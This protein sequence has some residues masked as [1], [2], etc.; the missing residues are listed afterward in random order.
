MKSLIITL[1]LLSSLTAQTIK[2]FKNVVIETDNNLMFINWVR[3]DTTLLIYEKVIDKNGNKITNEVCWWARKE[4]SYWCSNLPKDVETYI[5]NTK[6]KEDI[7]WMMLPNVSKETVF[8]GFS[9]DLLFKK[10]NFWVQE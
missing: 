4:G 8:I 9:Y 6:T 2:K 3:T 1:C 7:S 10:F 5:K